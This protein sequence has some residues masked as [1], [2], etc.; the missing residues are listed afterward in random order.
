MVRI[1]LHYPPAPPRKPVPFSK[2]LERIPRR[3]HGWLALTCLLSGIFYI[4]F[5]F[6]VHFNKP[7][8]KFRPLV[9]SPRQVA[10][11]IEQNRTLQLVEL[12]ED[13]QSPQPL[14]K[15]AVRLKPLAAASREKQEEQARRFREALSDRPLLWLICYS[16]GPE[17]EREV[18]CFIELLTQQGVEHVYAL[19]GSPAQWEQAG[20]IQLREN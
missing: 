20:L 5:G 9:V 11:W 18:S 6:Y 3:Y 8:E 19:G 2:G 17:T 10:W 16:L 12:W 15:G 13:D 4:I 7:P 14:L 1:K